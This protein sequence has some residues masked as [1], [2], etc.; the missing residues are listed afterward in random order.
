MLG[1]FV[2]SDAKDHVDSDYETHM[3]KNYDNK[4]HIVDFCKIF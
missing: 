1:P 2:F 3:A 4:G